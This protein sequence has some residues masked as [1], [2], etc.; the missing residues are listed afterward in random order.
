MTNKQDS[1]NKN[2]RDLKAE[3]TIQKWIPIV[4]ECLNSGQSKKEWCEEHGIDVKSF[5][6]YQKRIFDRAKEQRPEFAELPP[7][8]ESTL[9]PVDSVIDFEE[10]TEE[11]VQSDCIVARLIVNGITLELSNGIDSRTITSIVKGLQN[12]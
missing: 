9:I 11:T 2:L 12:V 5:Y 8:A 6:Y 4:S 1:L 10:P 3:A 7:P